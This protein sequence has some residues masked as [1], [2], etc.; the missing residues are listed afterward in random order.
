MTTLVQREVTSRILSYVFVMCLLLAFFEFQ[1]YVLA[2]LFDASGNTKD[3]NQINLVGC[4][5]VYS[6]KLWAA[7]V[8]MS[9]GLAAFGN[10]LIA[11]AAA[12]KTDNSWSGTAR[13][14]ASRILL[15]GLSI[16]IPL[17]FWLTYLAFAYAGIKIGDLTT[18]YGFA[19]GLLIV[20]SLLVTPNANSLHGYYRDRLSRAFL[21]RRD[22]LVEGAENELVARKSLL[23]SLKGLNKGWVKRAMTRSRDPDVDEFKLTSLKPGSVG[24][25]LDAVR[26][27]PYLIMNTAVNLGGSPYLGRRGRSADSFFLSPLY[28]GSQATGYVRT[29]AVEEAD[30]N[31]NLGTAM[32]ISGAAASANMGANTIRALTFSLAALN[33]R[34]GYWLPNPR[35][36]GDK[37]VWRRWLA[38]VAPWYFA[39]EA[40]GK[41]DELTSNVY[42]TDGGHFD[43]LGLY[44]L[45]KRRCKVIIVADAE[46]DPTLDFNALIRVERYARIDLGILI[47]LPWAELRRS[48]ALATE[49]NIDNGA[50]DETKFHGPHV[51]VGRIDYGEKEHG[52][53]IY[54]KSCMSGDE[55][56]MIRDYRRRYP[57]FPHQTTLDQF[58]DEE[59]FEVYR[60]LGF[61]A[62]RNFF[63]GRDRFACFKT[64]PV[65]DWAGVVRRALAQL[66]LPKDAVERIV[67]RQQDAMI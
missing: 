48:N 57:Q 36:L 3:C 56:D 31:L 65:K 19:A 35:F 50:D 13:H 8:A 1:A 64:S 27:S 40:I 14:W 39:K 4:A 58:F 15:Y 44:E 45:L 49:E 21:W 63:I 12:S 53:L 61:H 38:N 23:G 30:R 22:K 11:V 9:A 26:F 34:L 60:A 2:G 67:Q 25:W 59:Q 42:L 62:T 52:V 10:K 46:A 18:D 47:D 7:L 29:S 6:P 66:N 17:L 32:A 20:L 51:A 33:V 28:T 41:V 43:N 54:I 5:I 24:H 16:V 55:S 37:S